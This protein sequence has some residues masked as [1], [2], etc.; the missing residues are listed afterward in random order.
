MAIDAGY[1]PSGESQT[2]GDSLESSRYGCDVVRWEETT[3]DEGDHYA[4]SA[5]MKNDFSD[6]TLYSQPT[7]NAYNITNDTPWGTGG[8][9]PMG[10]YDDAW[11]VASEGVIPALSLRYNGMSREWRG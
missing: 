8:L 3:D 11:P 2:E 9:I 4:L 10:A 5:H 6:Y 1:F 7:Y